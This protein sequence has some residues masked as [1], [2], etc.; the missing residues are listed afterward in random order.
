MI[1]GSR[2]GSS[3]APT[4]WIVDGDSMTRY[5]DWMPETNASET[6]VASPRRSKSRYGVE[7]LTMRCTDGCGRIFSNLRSGVVS[8]THSLETIPSSPGG[9]GRS[10]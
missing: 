7:R 3:S 10:S 8:S 1:I 5:S 4:W 6:S 2:A 9:A